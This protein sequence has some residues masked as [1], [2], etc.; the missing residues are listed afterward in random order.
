MKSY[1]Q[2]L[3]HSETWLEKL[4]LALLEAKDW[5]WDRSLLDGT[6][7]DSPSNPRLERMAQAIKMARPITTPKQNSV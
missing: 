3:S 1:R 2:F 6:D 7:W 5:D 4:S